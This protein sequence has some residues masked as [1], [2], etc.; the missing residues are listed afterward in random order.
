[1]NSSYIVLGTRDNNCVLFACSAYYTAVEMCS[2]DVLGDP[3]VA[4]FLGAAARG[5]AFLARASTSPSLLRYCTAAAAP[6]S[7]LL[8][9][10]DED[11]FRVQRVHLAMGTGACI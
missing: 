4:T 1:M 5:L 7:C 3:T 11:A 2:E 10:G 9:A 6:L 8:D